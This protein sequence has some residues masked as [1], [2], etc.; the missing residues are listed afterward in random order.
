MPLP[1]ASAQDAANLDE[2]RNRWGWMLGCVR[3]VQAPGDLWFPLLNLVSTLIDGLASGPAGGSKA[4]YI[5]YVE[6]RFPELA[7]AIGA[8]VFYE[9]CRCKVVHEFGLAP[10][11]A[12][13]RAA[14]MGGRYSERQVIDGTEYVRMSTTV[15][16]S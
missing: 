13:A 16:P 15:H 6:T 10:G 8:Q 12:I 5:A 4:A 7:K 14:G 1:P 11:Y 2:P 3:A 9:K